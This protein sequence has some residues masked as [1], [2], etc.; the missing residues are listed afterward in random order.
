MN[1]GNFIFIMDTFKESDS[2]FLVFAFTQDG[3]LEFLMYHY[4]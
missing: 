4:D 1:K 3:N 2:A